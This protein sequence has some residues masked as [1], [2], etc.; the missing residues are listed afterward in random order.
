MVLMAIGLITTYGIILA[1][2]VTHGDLENHTKATDHVLSARIE[3]LADNFQY[4]VAAT[5]VWQ[6][7]TRLEDISDKRWSLKTRMEETN[8]NTRDNRDRDRDLEK[9]ETK[10]QQQISCLQQAG[11]HCL[12]NSEAG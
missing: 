6:L 2:F 12:N 5:T 11:K 1:T 7:E 4:H 8:G 9:R 3:L 10:L